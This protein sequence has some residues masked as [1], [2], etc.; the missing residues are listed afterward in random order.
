VVNRSTLQMNIKNRL[1]V[2]F[3]LYFSIV[4]GVVFITVYT[5]FA[6]FRK[7]EFK[8]R[9]QQKA[10]TTA[11]LLFEVKEIDSVLLKLIDKNTP[12]K[13][14]N[15]KLF[16]FDDNYQPVYNSTDTT[17]V[18]LTKQDFEQ[19][20]NGKAQLNIN[21]DY[22]V[23]SMYYSFGN[24][25][26]YVAIFAEDKYGNRK[27]RYLKFLLLAAFLI[28]S[29]AVWILSFVISKRALIPLKDFKE[30]IFSITDKNLN[31]RIEV[32]NPGDEI[33]TLAN[34]F[35]EML[36]RI[37]T[38]YRQEKVFTANASHEL[39]TPI[40]RIVTLLENLANGQKNNEPLQK[41]LKEIADDAY[42]L[43][44]VVTSLLLLS[45]I[46][47]KEGNKNFPSKIRIDE[48]LFNCAESLQQQHSNFKFFFEIKNETN[49]LDLEVNADESL[50]QIAFMNVLKNACQYSYDYKVTCEMK[51]TSQ[52]IRL[53]FSNTG[54]NPSQEELP[55][56][57]TAF[58]RG[59]NSAGT[60]GSGLGL[61]IV[62]RILDYHNADIFFQ[63]PSTHTNC[64]IIV[65]HK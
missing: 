33:G 48:L 44:D 18:H 47:N 61:S 12:N 16:V 4:L 23:Y 24:K 3:G 25:N 19:I 13:L 52:Q 29:I 54:D 46:E 17:P 36:H 63:I 64:I 56:L 34:T 43:S 57:F 37:N 35:N 60:T 5:L 10:E 40:T 15:E 55:H 7:D 30:Q 51:V 27:L 45:K 14:F 39:K 31:T 32:K 41:E 50:M 20:K 22:E 62:K 26:Y 53:S 8:D 21:D 6:D 9:L 65:F 1:S 42:Q 28:G 49:E 59:V 2:F 58:K 38:A 11:K